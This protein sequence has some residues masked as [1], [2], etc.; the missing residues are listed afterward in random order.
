MMVIWD[1]SLFVV[2]QIYSLGPVM[3]LYTQNVTSIIL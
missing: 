3:S 1:Y 2:V